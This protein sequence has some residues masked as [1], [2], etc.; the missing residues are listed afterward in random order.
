M[1]V[2]SCVGRIKEAGAVLPSGSML[3][4]RA[5]CELD[6]LRRVCSRKETGMNG[7]AAPSRAGSESW[8]GARAGCRGGRGEG[9]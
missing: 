9:V 4:G 7:G 2:G 6:R 5:S 1:G 8:E 3:P